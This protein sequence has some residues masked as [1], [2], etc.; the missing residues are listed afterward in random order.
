MPSVGVE[1]HSL[2]LALHRASALWSS[3]AY[4]GVRSLRAG[5]FHLPD[6]LL[7]QLN[8][9]TCRGWELNPQVLADIPY[10]MLGARVELA[11]LIQ[12]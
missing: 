3:P 9:I 6:P 2:S 10:K 12:A 8:Y 4:G 11:S 7:V 1:H 5:R